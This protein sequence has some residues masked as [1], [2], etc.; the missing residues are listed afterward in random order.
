M[1]DSGIYQILNLVNN[2]SYIGSAISISKRWGQ[3]RSALRKDYHENSYLQHAWN[4]YGELVFEFRVIGTCQPTDL[5]RMEQHLL[6]D[7]RP[8]YNISPTAGSQLGLV[9]SS[10][11]RA[12]LSARTISLEHRSK[13]SAARRGKSNSPETRAKISAAK[14]G[15]TTWSKGKTFSPEHRAKLSAAKKG[16]TNSPETRA[17]ISAALRRRH[18]AAQQEKE[19]C[20]AGGM[21]PVHGRLL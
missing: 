15:K 6:D 5:I 14:R 8:E 19:D 12:K 4:K 10:E 9:R 18:V 7:L 11:T 21:G 16:K 13:L 1:K 3:H 20:A 17:K 2:H